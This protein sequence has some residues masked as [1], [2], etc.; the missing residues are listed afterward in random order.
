MSHRLSSLGLLLCAA[1]PASADPQTFEID[2]VHTRVGFLVEH[3]GF[4]RAL[5]SFAASRGTLVF[6]PDDWSSARLDATIP[7]R[8]LELG[9]R[10]WEKATLGRNLLNLAQ[11][12]QA[13]FVST[14]VEPTGQD[15]LGRSTAKVTGDLSLR[16]VTRPVTL[17]VKFNQLKRHPLPPFRRTA[18]FS[19]TGRLSRADFG[20]S[21]WKNV[22]GDEVEL[23]IEVEAT[24]TRDDAAGDGPD[25]QRTTPSDENTTP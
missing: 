12:P 14:R 1:L 9:S 5:G 20:I 4:S 13:H 23:I 16:G 11:F 24:R 25:A 21:A 7:L 17:E 19:A 15:A 18:G 10:K 2:P 8:C 22:I 3:A 6:D